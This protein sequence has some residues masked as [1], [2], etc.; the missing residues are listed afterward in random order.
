MGIV[1]AIIQ[2]RWLN[3]I[4]LVING[5]DPR[6]AATM[7]YVLSRITSVVPNKIL[8]QVFVIYT[9]CESICDRN[10]VHA[11]LGYYF[12]QQ[13]PKE[14]TFYIDNPFSQ[15]DKFQ[16]PEVK[17]DPEIKKMLKDKIK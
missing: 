16:W 11:E 6:I 4:V 13:I 12:H 15:M 8:S 3:A 7:K 17:S 2:Q 14:R 5:R 1:H 9:N 10:F